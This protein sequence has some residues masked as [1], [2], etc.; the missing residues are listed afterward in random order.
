MGG[1]SGAHHGGKHHGGG[2]H[3]QVHSGAAIGAVIAPAYAYWPWWDYPPYYYAPV[4]VG[5]ATPVEYIEK[6]EQEGQMEQEQYWL[7]CAKAQAY[8]PYITE[9]AD[10]WER[11]PTTPPKQSGAEG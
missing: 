7:Y 5:P 6:G 4:A 3:G 10:G 9:C 1:R 8:F 11:V 2:H